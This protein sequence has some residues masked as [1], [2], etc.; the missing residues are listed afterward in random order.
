MI[1]VCA[2]KQ[3]AERVREL[4]SDNNMDVTIK[5]TLSRVPD[6]LQSTAK[7]RIAELNKLML[8]EI[9]KLKAI[10]ECA[11]VCNSSGSQQ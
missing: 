5:A 6:A 3:A 9:K 10:G 11:R 1:N 2:A 8:Q 7:A 4:V